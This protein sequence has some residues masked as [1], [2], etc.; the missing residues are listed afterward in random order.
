MA[1]ILDTSF[2][3]WLIS[4]WLQTLLQGCGLLQAWLYFH[5]YS[6]SNDHWGIR[7]MVI[8]L[9]VIETFQ[10][11]V[12]F[13]VT[14]FYLIDGFGDISG[15]LVIHWQDSAQLCATYLSAFIV[16]SYFGFCIYILDKKNKI[17]PIIIA[18]LALT[19]IGAGLA[20]TI[21]IFRLEK[22]DQIDATNSATQASLAVQAMATLLCDV[23]ITFSLVR[24][25]GKSMGQIKSTNS[26]LNTLMIYAINRG[27]LTAT[28]A[29]LNLILLLAFPGTF[30]FFIGLEMS[31]K[32]Y[33]NSVLATLNSR[34]HIAVIS[35]GND[36]S[37]EWNSIQMEG[38]NTARQG[39]YSQDGHV[40]I[41]ISRQSETDSDKRK[42][43][44][45]DGML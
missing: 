1:G 29:T 41:L 44:F 32:L 13:Q 19:Q 9:V 14:Y 8:S 22:F 45:V 12:F 10:I 11:V 35:N 26:I 34:Q 21:I 30:Y 28:C 25:S 42:P 7:V 2:G 4:I 3:F 15:L 36:R 38:M 16:Q 18:V 33:M 6:N 17:I 23:V 24:K 37:K 31:G 39:T 27:V 40:Q 43:N 5:W 20:Q